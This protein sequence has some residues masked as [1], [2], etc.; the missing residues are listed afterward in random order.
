MGS[1][2]HRPVPDSA[3]VPELG[4]LLSASLP[5]N[6][7]KAPAPQK[8]ELVPFDSLTCDERSTLFDAELGMGQAH[9]PY[10]ARKVGAA[11]RSGISGIWGCN[12]EG[13][14]REKHCAEKTAVI[15]MRNEGL[16][17]INLIAIITGRE[18]E[19]AKNLDPI[20]MC[21]SC[22]HLISHYA[23]ADTPV[24]L[25]STHK[26]I[27]YRTTVGSVYPLT[28]GT[29]N[30]LETEIA[31]PHT[32]LPSLK[33]LT[34]AE[35]VTNPPTELD[36]DALMY[37]L[38]E[39]E[40]RCIQGSGSAREG[41]AL[42]ASNSKVVKAAKVYDGDPSVGEFGAVLS[43]LT[44]GIS[45]GYDGYKA[46]AICADVSSPAGIVPPSGT[47][48]QYLF[49]RAQIFGYDMDIVMGAPGVERV[50]V[51]KISDLLPMSEGPLQ[52]NTALRNLARKLG[53]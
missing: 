27:I 52:S 1:I 40:E 19:S 11:I 33:I 38:L 34:R 16:Q 48:R 3:L 5:P 7:I 30:L 17:K 41:A 14:D 23:E 22:R 36:G 25:S 45:D 44:L 49:D 2:D 46:L 42:L 20:C 51:C 47:A 12:V 24:I 21:G 31:A 8:I 4:E 50:V 29:P 9:V 6:R 26:D 43:A 39:A 18:G 32:L 35:L 15:K 37:L 10:T 28:L 13:G 53:A